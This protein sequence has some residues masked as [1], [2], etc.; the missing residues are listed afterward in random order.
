MFPKI[1]SFIKANLISAEVEKVTGKELRK[2]MI[3]PFDYVK[4][5]TY[6]QI[7]KM[8]SVLQEDLNKHINE[9]MNKMFC[10]QI[11]NELTELNNIK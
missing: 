3:K 4:V 11:H 10:K 7:H 6:K 2:K 8:F 1:L 5:G 9:W